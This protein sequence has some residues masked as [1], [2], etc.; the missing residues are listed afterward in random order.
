MIRVK[1]RS[2]GE[3]TGKILLFEESIEYHT[4]LRKII[5]KLG[6][7]P[8]REFHDNDDPSQFFQLRLGDESILED[9]TEIEHGD[10]LVLT[11]ISRKR[12]NEDSADGTIKKERLKEKDLDSK[13]ATNEEA[14]NETRKVKK[15]SIPVHDYDVI[16]ISSDEDENNEDEDESLDEEGLDYWVEEDGDSSPSED[17]DNKN[18]VKAEEIA[19]AKPTRKRKQNSSMSSSESP[20]EVIMDEKDVPSAPGTQDEHTKENKAL[21]NDLDEVSL[22][23]DKTGKKKADKVVKDRIIKLLNTGFHDQSNEHEAKKC[24]EACSKADAKI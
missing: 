8:H 23:V 15:E 16:S 13:P 4:L 10:N 1:I 22:L 11:R 2:F 24:N 12:G 9:T 3:D 14:E 21:S 19:D 6:V 5:D 7:V 17:E 18:I 20:L